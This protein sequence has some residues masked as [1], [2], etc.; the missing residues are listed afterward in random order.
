MLGLKLNHVSKRGHWGLNISS[1]ISYCSTEMF[2][3]TLKSTELVPNGPNDNK[4]N[5]KVMA[6]R[7][8]DNRTL[9]KPMTVKFH[10]AIWHHKGTLIKCCGTNIVCLSVKAP[11]TGTFPYNAP[12]SW[13]GFIDC[14]HF[15][16]SN[17]I[18]TTALPLS[19]RH[20]YP[21]WNSFQLAKTFLNGFRLAGGCTASQPDTSF[22]YFLTSVD[23]TH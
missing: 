17:C 14:S 6:R 7:R 12:I 20:W 9:M 5:F 13:F 10:N 15:I 23:I 21:W 3:F 18:F 2:Q 4:S 16:C 19:Y 22:I 1:E 8:T 11:N